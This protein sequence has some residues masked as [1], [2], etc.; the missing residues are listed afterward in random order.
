M[1]VQTMLVARAHVQGRAQRSASVRHCR[2]LEDPMAVVFW[3]LGAELFSTAAIGYGQAPEDSTVEVAGDPRNR[4][5]AFR[6]LM[7]FAGPFI[8]YFEAPA[9]DRETIS[10]GS[11]E[12]ERSNSIPQVIVANSA[13]VTMIGNLGR[14]LAYLSTDGPY[15]ADPQL[16]R[17]GRHLMFIARHAFTP[18]QQ[19]IVSMT[20]LT[21]EHWVTALSDYEAASLSALDA[22]VEPPAG[23][24][25][26]HAANQAEIAPVGPQPEGELDTEVEPLIATFND[27]RGKRTEANVVLPLLGPIAEHYAP[28]VA[29]SYG[30]IWRCYERERSLP[31]APSV[32]RRFT[33]D[34]DEYTRHVDWT[35][36]V[37]HRRTRQTHRQAALSVRALEDAEALLK[38]EEATDDPLRMVGYLLD[39]K[40]FDGE[41]V[42]VDENNRELVNVKRMCRPLVTISCEEPCRI[43]RGRTLYW[44][45]R[46]QGKGWLLEDI[47]AAPGGGATVTMKLLTDRFDALPSVGER[48]CFS[49]LHVGTH[50]RQKLPR[51]VPWTHTPAVAPS[52]PEDIEETPAT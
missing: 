36:T 31:E 41:V 27:A 2:L 7:E 35:N 45:E 40:A 26:F 47:T 24:H 15:A 28:L 39:G 10:S 23:I 16:I 6:A 14:R 17:L 32:T 29:H 11:Y 38:A 8:D 4:D 3:Q 33:A 30:L 37:G 12:F 1:S 9:E 19:L 51:S 13:T 18:G 5:L 44:T 25:G 50:Y 34:C 22:Y 49:V 21:R 48:A 43:P 42:R 46:P 20:D 52:A